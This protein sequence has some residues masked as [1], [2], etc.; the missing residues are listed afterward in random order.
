MPDDA[1]RGALSLAAD[2]P[3]LCLTRVTEDESGPFQVDL[4]VFPATGQLLRYE[5]RIG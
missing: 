5:L 4:S 3:V 1:E 2:E